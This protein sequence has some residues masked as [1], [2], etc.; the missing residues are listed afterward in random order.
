MKHKWGRESEKVRKVITHPSENLDNQ[1]E[2]FFE[3]LADFNAK[4][5]DVDSKPKYKSYVFE[6][7]GVKL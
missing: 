4:Q 7:C 2:V 3:P 5:N 6:D 1:D